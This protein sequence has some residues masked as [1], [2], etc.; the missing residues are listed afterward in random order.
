[1]VRRV[2]ETGS[3]VVSPRGLRSRVLLAKLNELRNWATDI[4]NACL[5]AKSSGLVYV[6][7]GP[8]FGELEGNVLSIFKA[9]YGLK[10]SGLRWSERFADVLR[11]EGFFPSRAERDIWMREKDGLYEYIDV[12]VDDLS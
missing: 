8:E 4:G 7:A 12:Y 2:T 11:A 6:I 10:S 9:L 3:G 5:E 1:M